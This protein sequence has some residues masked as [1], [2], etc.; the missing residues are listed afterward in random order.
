MCDAGRDLLSKSIGN[1]EDEKLIFGH[2]IFSYP[3]VHD[4]IS[5]TSK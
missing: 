2:A 5:Q 4:V 3:K 1:K